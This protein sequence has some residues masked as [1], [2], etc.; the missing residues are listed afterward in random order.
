MKAVKMISSALEGEITGH[1][2]MYLDERV[3]KEYGDAANLSI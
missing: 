3:R 2:A 1:D